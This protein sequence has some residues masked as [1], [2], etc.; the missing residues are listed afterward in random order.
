MKQ[1]DESIFFVAPAIGLLVIFS[2]IC[3]FSEAKSSPE[4]AEMPKKGLQ[5]KLIEDS[6]GTLNYQV[7]TIDGSEYIATKDSYGT[8]RLCPKLPP[9]IE[10]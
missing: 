8:W 3:I 9:Q 10:K 1:K 5:L 7:V 2:V 6:G 4:A